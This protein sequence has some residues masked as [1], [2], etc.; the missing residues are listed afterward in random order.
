M[1]AQNFQIDP[2]SYMSG[3]ANTYVGPSLGTAKT[4]V[5]P[6]RQSPVEPT[7]DLNVLLLGPLGGGWF[8]DKPIFLDIEQDGDGSFVAVESTFNVYGIGATK[9]E[10]LRDYMTS[11]VEFYELTEES[12]KENPYD[13]ALLR[14]LRVY[15][16]RNTAAH[17]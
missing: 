8:V 16:R 14:Q 3:R 4:Q 11:L 13:T 15:L 6:S 9:T 17:R 10:A 5:A 12:A 7:G 1:Q 2:Y